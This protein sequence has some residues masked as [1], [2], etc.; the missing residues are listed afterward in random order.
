[1][2]AQCTGYELQLTE[3]MSNGLQLIRLIDFHTVIHYQKEDGN[4]CWNAISLK[5]IPPD[6]GR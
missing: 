2:Y 6:N 4:E 5:K 1:M 3:M